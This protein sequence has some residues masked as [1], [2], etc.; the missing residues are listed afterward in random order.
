MAP[1]PPIESCGVGEG[2]V[3][4]ADGSAMS[5]RTAVSVGP[6]GPTDAPTGYAIYFADAQARAFRGLV[7]MHQRAACFLQQRVQI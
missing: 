6:V 4:E 7:H 2:K 1:L 5:V 3:V